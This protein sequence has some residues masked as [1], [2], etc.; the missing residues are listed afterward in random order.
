MAR[1][2]ALDNTLCQFENGFSL[3]E[4]DFVHLNQYFTE[5]QN[6][7]ENVD[8][9][10]RK[11]NVRLQGLEERADKRNLAAYLEDLFFLV[12]LGQTQM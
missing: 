7:V 1:T 5:L 4:R 8:N 6:T 10:L 12:V 9:S 2:K 3:M 11:L